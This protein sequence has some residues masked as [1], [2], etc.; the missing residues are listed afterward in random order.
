MKN[1]IERS[2]VYTYLY[3]NVWVTMMWFLY[4]PLLSLLYVVCRAG[5]M[6]VLGSAGSSFLSSHA[7][8]LY[9]EIRSVYLGM[10]PLENTEKRLVREY[11]NNIAS[12]SHTEQLIFN[13]CLRICR[14]Y[15]NLQSVRRLEHLLR[16]PRKVRQF[17]PETDGLAL[18]TMLEKN[19][20]S[21]L[22]SR[23]IYR[24]IATMATCYKYDMSLM[25]RSP[26]L[27]GPPGTGKTRLI[28]QVASALDLPCISVTL[29]HG[30]SMRSLFGTPLTGHHHDEDGVITQFM[31]NQTN[32]AGVHYKENTFPVM[33][34]FEEIEK[35]LGEN[36]H[37]KIEFHQ[38]LN[39]EDNSIVKIEGL[40]GIHVELNRFMFWFDANKEVQTEKEYVPV[41][42]VDPFMNRMNVI[43]IEKQTKEGKMKIVK[44]IVDNVMKQTKMEHTDAIDEI[45]K[46][47]I[48]NDPE[49]G[50]RSL[51]NE[52]LVGLISHLAYQEG[53]NHYDFTQ[54]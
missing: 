33:V 22:V 6:M 35:H 46:Q 32:L 10:E 49:D 5:S 19:H 14:M 52:V 21:P 34:C 45:I 38:L 31:C 12:Y 26:F 8:Q 37:L 43:K 3:E 28:R 20:Y 23:E 13:D 4:S 2:S 18:F 25:I 29:D 15:R 47:A 53:W 39:T 17:Y 48:E 44:D 40:G 30:L 1:W 51:K 54:Q 50:V 41:T 11:E 27:L 9:I 36:E 42:D 16:M 7:D 24:Y